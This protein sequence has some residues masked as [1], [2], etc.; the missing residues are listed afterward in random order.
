[1][2]NTNTDKFTKDMAQSLESIAYSTGRL[3]S[4]S[5]FSGTAGIEECLGNINWTLRCIHNC[6]Q[7][8]LENEKT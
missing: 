8:L 7:Q 6:L 5:E 4:D 2:T 3:A 1:M